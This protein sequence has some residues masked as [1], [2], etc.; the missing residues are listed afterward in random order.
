[1]KGYIYKLEGYDR[2]CSYLFCDVNCSI[3]YF[4]INNNNVKYQIIYRIQFSLQLDKIRSKEYFIC[5]SVY[6]TI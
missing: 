6:N 3:N 5:I 2:C 1:M 4:W